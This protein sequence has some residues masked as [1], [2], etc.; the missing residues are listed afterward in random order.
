MLG[1]APFTLKIDAAT[2]EEIIDVKCT[3]NICGFTALP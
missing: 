3:S 2:N 1:I